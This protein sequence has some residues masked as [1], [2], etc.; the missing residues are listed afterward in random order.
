ML[1]LV[2]LARAGA[3]LAYDAV[4]ELIIE[5]KHGRREMPPPLAAFDM[6]K[7]DP[8]HRRQRQRGKKRADYLMRDIA[9]TTIVA[10]VCSN[11]GLKPTRQW[12]SK[13]ERPSGCGIVARAMTEEGFPIGDGAVMA[14]WTRYN[15]VA[16]PRGFKP[17]VFTRR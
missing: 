4:L 7:D 11:F 6:E 2:S 13:Q 14:I 17:R 1:D 5:H 12:Y 8:R 15:R 3:D 9:V 16:F 10:E